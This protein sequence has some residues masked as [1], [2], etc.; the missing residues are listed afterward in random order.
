[1]AS[2][3]KAKTQTIQLIRGVR[4]YGKSYF[5]KTKQ[6]NKEVDTIITVTEQL[7]QQLISAGKAKL[8]DKKATVKI[9]A[10]KDDLEAELAELDGG[11]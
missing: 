10:P 2:K 8:T 4:F 3:T 6:G 9:E 5:A 7:A 11:E 1:M